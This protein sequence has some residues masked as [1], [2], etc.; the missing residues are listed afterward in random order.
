[1]NLTYFTGPQKQHPVR[2]GAPLHLRVNTGNDF[3]LLPYP[4]QG[5]KKLL[6]PIFSAAAKFHLTILRDRTLD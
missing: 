2:A 1:M 5:P 6:F 4:L 3:R